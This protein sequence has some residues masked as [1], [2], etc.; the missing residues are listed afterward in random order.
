[1]QH[2]VAAAV[3]QSHLGKILVGYFVLRDELT[4]DSSELRGWLQAR[5]PSYMVPTS[6]I[7]ID[8]VPL[9]SNGKIDRRALPSPGKPKSAVGQAHRPPANDVERQLVEIWKSVLELDHVGV[10][11]DFFA[12]GGQSLL[13]I[14]LLARV[15]NAFGRE[16]PLSSFLNAPTIEAQ[17]T[18]LQDSSRVVASDL[19]VPLHP[20]GTREPLFLI[21]P[22]GGNTL[23]YVELAK[24][25]ACDRPVY[26]LQAAAFAGVPELH[27]ISAMAEAYVSRIRTVQPH[28]PYYLGGWSLGGIIAYEIA[29]RLRA[30]QE[31]VAL[32]AIIDSRTRSSPPDSAALLAWFMRD[33]LG[34]KSGGE[35]ISEAAL[36]KLPEEHRISAAFAIVQQLGVLD[37]AVSLSRFEALFRVFALHTRAL[38]AHELTAAPLA[39]HVFRASDEPGVTGSA[40]AFP[41]VNGKLT[42]HLLSGNHYTIMSGEH[43][44]ELLQK[45]RSL[46]S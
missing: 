7:R 9:S 26:G 21:H 30:Q 23:C 14:R 34:P 12:L 1:V 27:T 40:T 35:S 6:L 20:H 46:L 11:S 45:L 17:A 24:S 36:Q 44:Q 3:G 39:I 13:A 19:L 38:H 37:A 25:L 8:T 10:T 15:Q 2:A 18:L 22:V 28:G 42:E 16:L 41:L 4:V 5:L 43:L 32:I 29:A 31:S 33:L